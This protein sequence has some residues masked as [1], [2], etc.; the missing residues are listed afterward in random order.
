MGSRPATAARHGA[1]ARGPDHRT[2]RTPPQDATCRDPPQG[3]AGQLRGQM[4]RCLVPAV[5]LPAAALPS[6]FGQSAGSPRATTPTSSPGGSSIAA[7]TGPPTTPPTSSPPTCASSSPDS[8]DHPAPAPLP[9]HR[10]APTQPEPSTSPMR[11]WGVGGHPNS[12]MK[13]SEHA[14]S[15]GAPLHTNAAKV[16]GHGGFA[17]QPAAGAL[18][19]SR[20]SFPKPL[21]R[22]ASSGSCPPRSA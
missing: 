5:G 15:S 22:P 17:A 6:T 14:A 2:G 9:P 18:P 16:T 7:A 1:G 12:T 13:A 21:D 8:A 19:R 10:P 3:L 11:R 20:A 4:P